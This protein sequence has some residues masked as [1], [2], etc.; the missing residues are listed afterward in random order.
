MKRLT[1]KNPV[2][3]LKNAV[4][5]D[6]EVISADGM[7]LHCRHCMRKDCLE[8]VAQVDLV[9]GDKVSYREF[10]RCTRCGYDCAIDSEPMVT[11]PAKMPWDE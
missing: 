2:T 3:G 10:V 5:M 6:Y 11:A 4:F 9:I 1:V 8:H 7:N